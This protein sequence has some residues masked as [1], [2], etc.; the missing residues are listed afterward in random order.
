MNTREENCPKKGLRQC[1]EIG[2]IY[3]SEGSSV[4]QLPGTPQICFTGNTGLDL[5]F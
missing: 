5:Q 2:E 3:P 4:F 1:A